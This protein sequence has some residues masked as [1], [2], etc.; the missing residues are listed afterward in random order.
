MSL[1]IGLSLILSLSSLLSPS[2]HTSLTTHYR[3]YI[4]HRLSVSQWFAMVVL[5]TVATVDDAGGAGGRDGVVA[6]VVVVS[7][8]RSLINVMRILGAVS[9]GLGA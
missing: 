4:V 6:V 8:V 9:R 2:Y 3:N 1:S 7:I 5:V